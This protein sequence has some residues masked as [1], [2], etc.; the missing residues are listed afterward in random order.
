MDKKKVNK[1]SIVY[2]YTTDKHHEYYLLRINSYLKPDPEINQK[3]R[4]SNTKKN[5]N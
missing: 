5:K 4:I 3:I 1:N 2:S